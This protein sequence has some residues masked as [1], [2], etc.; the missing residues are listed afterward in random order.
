MMNMGMSAHECQSVARAVACVMSDTYILYLK[1][2]NFHWNVTGPLFTNLHAMFE[3][4]Y[5]ALAE[6]IDELAERIRALGESAPGAYQIYSKLSTLQEETG[7]PSSEAMIA[8]LLED[9]ETIVRHLRESFDIIDEAG[10]EAT[11][12]LF[13]QRLAYHEKTAWMLRAMID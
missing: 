10:D 8:Q 6:A 11:A 3:S 12:D 13:T 4:Q 5:K 2:Q 1:T 7:V 9:H